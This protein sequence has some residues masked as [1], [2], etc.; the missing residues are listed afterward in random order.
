MIKS[1]KKIRKLVGF[2]FA[3]ASVLVSSHVNGE[4]SENQNRA[5]RKAPA[6]ASPDF[7]A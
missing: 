6:R 2:R 3:G 7:T 5:D 4:T 1:T